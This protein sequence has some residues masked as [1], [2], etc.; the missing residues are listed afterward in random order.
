MAEPPLFD[1]TSVPD[2]LFDELPHAANVSADAATTASAT[3]GRLKLRNDLIE[4]LLRTFR[5]T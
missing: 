1:V 5:A 2:E 4:F 3:L